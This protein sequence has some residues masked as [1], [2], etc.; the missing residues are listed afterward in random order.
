MGG[1]TPGDMPDMGGMPPGNMPDMENM[2]DM[3]GTPP[4]D[5]PDMNGFTPPGSSS[6]Q[7]ETQPATEGDLSVKATDDEKSLSGNR[8][9]FSGMPGQSGGSTVK[10][11][12]TIGICL[13]VMIAAVLIVRAVKRKR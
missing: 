7:E 12:I 8:P 11:L 1:M 13:V 5:M 2:P 4:G 3:N 9:S 6:V 10:N